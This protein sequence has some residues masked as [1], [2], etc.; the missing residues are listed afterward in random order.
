MTVAEAGRM[1]GRLVREKYGPE[2][3]ERI[4]KKGGSIDKT[5]VTCT[6]TADKSDA[7]IKITT[8]RLSVS[9]EGLKGMEPGDFAALPAR[10]AA[11]AGALY[12]AVLAAWV[13]RQ[14]A[15][16]RRQSLHPGRLLVVL[17]TAV[18]VGRTLIAILEN[19]QR[20]D[21]GVAIPECLRPFGA[22]EVLSPR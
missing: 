21:G 16:A 3:Y 4:G 8:S 11:P 20:P 18:A 5:T 6:V 7:G 12:A 14:A 19:H 9:V 13:L 10:L 22:P 1:G 15:R 2:F 17:G